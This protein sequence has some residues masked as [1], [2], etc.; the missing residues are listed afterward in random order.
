MVSDLEKK[1][2]LTPI[3]RPEQDYVFPYEETGALV[4]K[5]LIKELFT[6]E[7]Y[8]ALLSM[9]E[10]AA[11]EI[12]QKHR[13]FVSAKE[14]N[15]ILSDEVAKSVIEEVKS[16]ER[17]KGK[18]AIINVDT[19]SDYFEANDVVTLETLRE[20]GL[21]D[22]SVVSVK[23]LARGALNKPLTVSLQN[24]SLEA[25]KMIVLTGGKVIKVSK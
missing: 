4:K 18:K 25:V 1:F 22:S 6:K 17:R 19:L 23:V 12:D 16:E 21:I 2:G 20:K 13:D 11:L 15:T 5:G 3:D 8:D 14:V 10:K 9:R 7:K 24:Y